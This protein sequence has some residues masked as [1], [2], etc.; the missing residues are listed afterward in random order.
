MRC[1]DSRALLS[2]SIDG[3][4]DSGQRGALDAHL[5][6]CTRC[7]A[8]L[9]SL[10]ALKHAIARLPSHE[11][12][13]GAVRARVEASRL[14]RRSRSG[15]RLLLAPALAGAAVA[16]A[17]GLQLRHE[18]GDNGAKLADHLVWDHLSS[19]P[20][21]RPAEIASAD[22]REI[23]SFFSGHLPFQPTVP[24]LP[25]ADLLGAR[26]CQLEGRRVELIFYQREGRTLSL[27]ITDGAV[28]AGR[29]WEAREHHVCSRPMGGLTFLAVAELPEQELRRLLEEATPAA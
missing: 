26:L 23:L 13:P 1:S 20:E 3:A 28:P 11:E 2:A 4:L 25:G 5:C 24:R 21:V 22:P 6:E 16:L 17:L 15:W 12:P 29:C 9:A 19:V 27:F 7:R 8:E 14:G 18:R 10:R